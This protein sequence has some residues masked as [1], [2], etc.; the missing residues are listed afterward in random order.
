MFLNKTLLKKIIYDKIMART[1]MSVTL[2]V[3]VLFSQNQNYFIIIKLISCSNKYLMIHAYKRIYTVGLLYFLKGDSS[4]FKMSFL[5]FSLYSF[6][7]L[8]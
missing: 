1:K 2:F 3:C 7:I 8:W 4:N 5:I 6:V